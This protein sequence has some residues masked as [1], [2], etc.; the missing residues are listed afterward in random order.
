MVNALGMR[1]SR[2][3]NQTA[4]SAR[5]MRTTVVAWVIIWEPVKG[6]LAWWLTRP[7]RLGCFN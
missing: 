1:R 4:P 7:P 3:S 6:L 5:L 2:T